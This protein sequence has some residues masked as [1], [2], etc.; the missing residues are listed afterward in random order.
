MQKYIGFVRIRYFPVDIKTYALCA[1][2]R[3]T[4]YERSNCGGFKSTHSTIRIEMEPL[5]VF[6]STDARRDEAFRSELIALD[7]IKSR[8][9]DHGFAADEAAEA[10]KMVNVFRPFKVRGVSI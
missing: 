2:A 5:Q 7:L 10:I 6:P 9:I 4:E 3:Y 8:L 1:D